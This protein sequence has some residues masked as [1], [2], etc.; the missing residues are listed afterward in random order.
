MRAGNLPSTSVNILCS[1]ETFRQ[2]P[3]A[4]IL[5][6]L[7]VF[8]STSVNFLCGWEMCQLSWMF[9]AAW[10]PSFNFSKLSERP[11]DFLSTSIKF[12]CGQMTFI[13][14]FVRADYLHSTFV[15]PGDLLSSFVNFIC[16]QMTFLQPSM[17][18]GDLQRTCIKFLCSW[19]TYRQ[20]SVQPEDGRPQ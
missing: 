11:G 10:R 7:A 18:S 6:H 12:T 17:Q 13:Q 9:R 5:V 1:R 14:P 16:G 3:S 20:F 15:Q 4:E 19:D 8:S 2:L